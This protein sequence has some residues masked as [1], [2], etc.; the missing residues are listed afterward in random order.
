MALLVEAQKLLRSI[1]GL[2]PRRL[3]QLAAVGAATLAAVGVAS[4]LASRPTFEVLYSGLDPQDLARVTSL[5]RETSVP[6]DISADGGTLLVEYGHA[7]RA[8]ML[9]ADKGLPRSASA[10]YELFEKLGSLGLTS[11]MQELTRIRALEGELA[12]SIQSMQGVRAARVHIAPQEESG[13]RRSKQAASASVIVRLSSAAE[14]SLAQAIRRLV[15]AA[16]PGLTIDAVTVLNADGS[17]LA[18]GGES[19]AT[20]PLHALGIEKNLSDAIQDNIRQTLAPIVGARNLNVSVALRVNTDKRQVNETVYNPDS[21]V[22]RSVRVI[23]E[24]QSAQNSNGQMPTSVE[25]NIPNDKTKADGK[26]SNEENNKKEELTNYEISS[27]SVQ[28]VGGSYTIERLSVAVLINRAALVAKL[29]E[30]AEGLLDRRMSELTEL[31]STAAGFTRDR[32]DAIKVAAIDFS[33]GV[34]ELAPVGEPS[35]GSI[36]AR[37]LGSILNALAIVVVGV[38]AGF[39]AL[40]TVERIS[41]P[42]ERSQNQFVSQNLA[43]LPGPEGDARPTADDRGLVENGSS[44]RKRAQKRLEA[45]VDADAEQAAQVIKGWLRAEA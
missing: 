14:R 29:G 21:R 4:F 11:F 38:T 18:A 24:N 41:R 16:T 34:S 8:R 5:L 32:G 44:Q 12:R 17:I 1:A 10:G 2:G 22:E 25:R 30:K 28:T 7:S 9:L 6:F 40:R 20:G 39:V 42:D 35:L 43:E 15:A 23:K 26:V 45:L 37:Q 13:F 31:A 36:A 27:K 3:W 19:D 33:E